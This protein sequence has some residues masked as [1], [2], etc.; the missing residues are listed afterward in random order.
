MGLWQFAGER[1]LDQL[2]TLWARPHGYTG[3]G[4]SDDYLG[5]TNTT[6]SYSTPFWQPRGANGIGKQ[7]TPFFV[8]PAGDDAPPPQTTTTT[9]EQLHEQPP[10]ETERCAPPGRT[11]QQMACDANC[12]TPQGQAR[13]REPLRGQPPGS[14]DDHKKR[15]ATIA[16]PPP[17]EQLEGGARPGGP[18][19]RPKLDNAELEYNPLYTEGRPIDTLATARV[20]KVAIKRGNSIDITTNEN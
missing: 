19:K 17:A 20:S 12:P 7:P 15:R 11:P 18:C 10:A 8:L 13:P 14:S 3:Q 6:N 1:A 16:P 5:Q 2:N 9:E 4:R